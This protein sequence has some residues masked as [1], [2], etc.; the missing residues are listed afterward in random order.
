MLPY[1]F[2]QLPMVE[3]T[4]SPSLETLST[5]ELHAGHREAG[6]PQC[7][8]FLSFQP[9]SLSPPTLSFCATM[10]KQC[11]QTRPVTGLRTTEGLYQG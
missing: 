5:A 8:E 11:T 4:A 7:E 1:S 6:P 3:H 10:K 9:F 2:L